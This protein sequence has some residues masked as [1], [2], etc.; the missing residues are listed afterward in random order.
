M[1][2]ISS[3][4]CRAQCVR[5]GAASKDLMKPSANVSNFAEHSRIAGYRDLAIFACP[6][7]NREDKR[8]LFGAIRLR[9]H[10]RLH[11]PAE[12]RRCLRC[13]A[14]VDRARRLPPAP[15][16]HRQPD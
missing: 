8:T 12:A 2:E 7:L 6:M 1:I 11:Y 16:V 13:R 9:Y 14:T 3:D 5:E 4:I 10:Y 15:A